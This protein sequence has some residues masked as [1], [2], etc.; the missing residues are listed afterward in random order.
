MKRPNYPFSRVMYIIEAALEYFISIM[1]SGAYLA[2]IA[3]E[4]GLSDSTTGILT[5]FVSL[6]LGFQVFGLFLR[7]RTPVKRWVSVL[8]IVNQCFFALVWLTPVFPFSGTGKAALFIVFL[9]VGHLLSNVLGPSKTNWFMSLVEDGKRGVFTA[10][11]EIVSLISGMVFSYLMGSLYDHFEATGETVLAFVCGGATL[12]CLMLLHT[13]TLLLSDEKPVEKRDRISLRALFADKKQTKT[14]FLVIGV[15]VLWAVS[16]YIT[17]PFYGTYQVKELGF[18][19]TFVSVLGILYAVVRA[20]VSRLMGRFADR[21]SFASM[22]NICFTV[23]SVAF[24]VNTFTVPENGKIFYSAYYALYAIGMAGINS[25]TVNLIYDYVAPENRTVALALSQSISGVSG[26]LATYL[27]G[28]P[29]EWIQEN[30]LV[31]FGR[32]V[33]AQQVLSACG[34]VG[35]VLTLLYT[36]LVVRKMK[37]YREN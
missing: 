8:H 34:V 15:N 25:A 7:N 20:S 36:N 16:H 11:K 13:V 14:I 21:H 35:V 37:R 29:V 9:L 19:M 2:K 30:G 31:L 5:S 32:N 22:L 4:V 6:G 23:V 3:G 18:S 10:N 12:F 1:I 33:Y 26:F 27:A 17:T 28:F 24:L